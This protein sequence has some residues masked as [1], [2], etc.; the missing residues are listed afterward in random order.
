MAGG[1]EGRSDMVF[2]FFHVMSIAETR[3]GN[4]PPTNL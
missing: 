1:W 3:G 4:K 2:T